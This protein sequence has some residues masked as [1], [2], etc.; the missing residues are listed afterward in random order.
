MKDCSDIILSEDRNS[1][2][3]QEKILKNIKFKQD[4]LYERTHSNE[5][6][7]NVV[8]VG[9]RRKDFKKT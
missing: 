1:G 9:V 4:V 2:I 8:S 6:I 3:T 7:L 5:S